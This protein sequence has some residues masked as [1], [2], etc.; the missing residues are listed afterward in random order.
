MI[1]KFVKKDEL[2][3]HKI[4]L[5]L[6]TIGGLLIG[7]VVS[8]RADRFEIEEAKEEEGSINGSEKA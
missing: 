1:E 2:F 3:F 4:G 7:F 8:D 6:G 5:L